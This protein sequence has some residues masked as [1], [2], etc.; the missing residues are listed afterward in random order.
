[1]ELKKAMKILDVVMCDCL[2]YVNDLS[3]NPTKKEVGEAIQALENA[4]EKIGGYEQLEILIAKR[5]RK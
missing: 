2:G 3:C 4:L 1:M 5:E